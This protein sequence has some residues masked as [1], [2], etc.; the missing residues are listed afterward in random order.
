M[1]VEVSIPTILRTYTGG[2]KG[3]EASGATLKAV[4]DDPRT[5]AMDLA[6]ERHLIGCLRQAIAPEVTLVLSTHRYSMLD[7]IDRLIVIENGRLIADGPKDQ[8]IAALQ[9]K[10][11][12]IQ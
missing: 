9:R 6:S 4:I 12:G 10:S 2:A 1:A 8:V 3:V 7:L 11:N 5:G